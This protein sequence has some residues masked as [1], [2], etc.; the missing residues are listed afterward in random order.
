LSK[1]KGFF[2]EKL[3]GELWKGVELKSNRKLNAGF[4]ISSKDGSVYYDFSSESVA[5][6]LST[7]LNSKLAEILKNSSKGI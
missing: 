4:H 3:T 5:Q 2:S 1:L 7:Y 6:L